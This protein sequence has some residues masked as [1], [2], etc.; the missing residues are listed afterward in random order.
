M[1]V[2]DEIEA[3]VRARFGASAETSKVA[4]VTLEMIGSLDEGL[5]TL[6]QKFRDA[7]LKEQ[8]E[9]WVAKGKNL[10]VTAAQVKAA[11]GPEKLKAMAD[12]MGKDV[13]T[14]AKEIAAAL[15][16]LVDQLTP[17]GLAPKVAELKQG[18]RRLVRKL[19]GGG[20]GSGGAS[21][22]GAGGAAPGGQAGAGPAGTGP[23][24]GGPAPGGS[25]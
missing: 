9:S 13:E 6:A 12:Q 19:K 11:L 21:G 4:R 18:A 8:V 1:S 14:A 10:P 20:P 24:S 7:G 17:D 16:E 2:F 5:D 25:A 23:A 22:P 3:K 15:P